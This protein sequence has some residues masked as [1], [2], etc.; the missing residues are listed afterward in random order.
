MQYL[1]ADQWKDA[2]VAA[3]R[4]T[5]IDV[6]GV[7][8]RNFSVILRTHRS[9][10]AVSWDVDSTT[11]KWTVYLYLPA[12]SPTAKLT[13]L[14]ADILAGYWVHEMCH[15]LYTDKAVWLKAVSRGRAFRNLVNGLEDAGSLQSWEV[16]SRG[17]RTPAD[18]S[19]FMIGKDARDAT[20]RHNGLHRLAVAITL[21]GIEL[22]VSQPPPHTPATTC[23]TALAEE[24]LEIGPSLGGQGAERPWPLFA[25]PFRCHMVR[26]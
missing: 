5:A 24:V 4:R 18:R 11:G 21:S 20:G 12:M 16:V 26:A 19:A 9:T 25:L 22:L 17:H 2:A 8:A 7:S 14:D 10:A 13:R 1:T 23:G 3:F 6:L 15:V